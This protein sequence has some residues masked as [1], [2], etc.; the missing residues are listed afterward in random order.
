MSRFAVFGWE[1]GEYA[2][3]VT[4]IENVEDDYEL[5][6]GVPRLASWPDDAT[7]RMDEDFPDDVQLEDVLRAGQRV[8]VASERFKSFLVE[9]APR[10]NEFLPVT[11]LNHK[12]RRV[13][14]PYWV[15][16]Q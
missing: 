16:H 1:P 7:F 11:I 8:I 6:R 13:R 14:E 9:R 4:V 5:L 15:V 3:E 10:N 12:G 2:A